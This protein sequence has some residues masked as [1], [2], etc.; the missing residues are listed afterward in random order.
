MSRTLAADCIRL[1]CAR[2]TGLINPA[3]HDA[4]RLPVTKH[5]RDADCNEVLHYFAYC[6]DK[7][8]QNYRAFVQKVLVCA[9]PLLHRGVAR[10]DAAA[11]ASAVADDKVWLT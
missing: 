6:C 4:C 3:G 8:Q 7:M 11:C 1:T 9:K 2:I 10:P 5:K